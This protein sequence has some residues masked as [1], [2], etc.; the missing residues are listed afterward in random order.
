MKLFN[1]RRLNNRGVSHIALPVLAVLMVGVVGTYMMVSSSANSA[2]PK[3]KAA[4]VKDGR[5]KVKAV[6]YVC[7]ARGGDLEKCRYRNSKADLWVS[8]AGD[9]AQMN[10]NLVCNGKEIPANPSVSINFGTKRS[11][12]CK[13]G[14]YKISLTDPRT[15]DPPHQASKS[16]VVSLGSRDRVNIRLG[17][18]Y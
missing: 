15:F 1:I 9:E 13:P 5:I 7:K 8:A 14:R 10:Q 3:A 12:K 18:S 17:S 16:E 2:A 11:L 6:T 4:K